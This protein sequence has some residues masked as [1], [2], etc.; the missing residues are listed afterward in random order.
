V[1]VSSTPIERTIVDY[2]L[3][4]SGI[5][6]R[7]ATAAVLLSAS[8]ASAATLTQKILERPRLLERIRDAT[9]D[10]AW[11]IFRASTDDPERTLP[12]GSVSRFMAAIRR[13]ST[14]VARAAP[15]RR[16]ASAHT[17]AR[18]VRDL[19]SVDQVSMRSPISRCATRR[20]R[21]PRSS[22]TTALRRGKRGVH[23]RGLRGGR[24]APLDRSTRT[25]GTSHSRR[26]T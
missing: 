24:R 5:A 23:L 20:C 19:R 11:R 26:A 13:C 6:A 18:R 4:C 14:W 22:S 16:F 15:A 17:V 7:S 2:Y 1:F 25:A 9:G 10:P 21:V 12:Y 8:D 3:D